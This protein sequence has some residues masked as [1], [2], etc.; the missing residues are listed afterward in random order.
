M[1]SANM[2]DGGGHPYSGLLRMIVLDEIKC[3]CT[4]M[5]AEKYPVIGGSLLNNAVDE[6]MRS[7][8]VDGAVS[9]IEEIIEREARAAVWEHVMAYGVECAPTKYEILCQ[10]LEE[11]ASK[12]PEAEDITER[13][14]SRVA[15]LIDLRRD[16]VVTS[17]EAWNVIRGHVGNKVAD[18]LYEEFES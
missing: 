17:F 2:Y 7:V 4:D 16:G 12:H 1:L 11:F 9:A 13:T 10:E 15:D 14:W 3:A 8:D 5:A 18:M 6:I